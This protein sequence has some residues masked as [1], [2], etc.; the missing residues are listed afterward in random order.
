MKTEKE[1]RKKNGKWEEKKI[2]EINER[3]KTYKFF[4]NKI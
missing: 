1:A 4:V 2:K 3:E